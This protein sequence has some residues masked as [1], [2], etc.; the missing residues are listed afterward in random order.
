[1]RYLFLLVI[2]I[3]VFFI[4]RAASRRRD[5]SPP[6]TPEPKTGDMVQCRRCGVYLP[7]GDAINEGAFFYCSEAHRDED[8][9]GQK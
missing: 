4:W 3:V 8:R 1:M 2:G 7:E 6:E 5:D 9:D